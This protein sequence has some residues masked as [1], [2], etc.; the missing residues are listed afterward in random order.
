MAFVPAP[1]IVQVEIR[2]TLDSQQIENVIDVDALTAV[3]PEIV[4]DICNL[5]NVWAQG[6]YFDHLPVAVSLRE[7]V[8][9]DLT[10]QNG[11]QFTIAPTGPFT[12]AINDAPMPNETTFCITHK[13]TSRGRSARGRSYVLGI[14]KGDVNDNNFSGVRAGEFVSDFD[15][16]KTTLAD[17]G[18]EW[19]VVSYRSNNA[20]RPGGPVYFAIATNSFTDLLID[21]MRRR[22]PGVGS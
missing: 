9:T 7:V 3:T 18:Y 2:A 4:E 13:S 20:P 15:A 22:K 21:S 11:A 10:V 12:G 6:T 8:A 14:T 19:V 16:L 1:Q 17:A 5:V